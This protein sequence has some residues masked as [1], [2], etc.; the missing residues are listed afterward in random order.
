MIRKFIV[1]SLMLVL[2]TVVHSCAKDKAQPPADIDCT[3]IDQSANTYNLKVKAI[4]DNSCAAIAC[5][6]PIFGYNG[7]NLAT[8]DG[9]KNAFQT[10]DVLCTVKHRQGCTPMPQGAPKL[11]DSLIAYLHCWAENNYPQ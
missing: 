3:T 4:L 8:Y 11:A 5:H 9:A 7:I 10:K 2:A 1:P 6:D